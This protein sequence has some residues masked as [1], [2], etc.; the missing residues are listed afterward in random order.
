MMRRYFIAALSCILAVSTVTPAAAFEFNPSYVISDSEMLDEDSMTEEQIRAFLDA[1]GT[2]GERTFTDVDDARKGAAEI[3]YD[4][5]QRNG[6]NP[7]VILVMLQKEQSL[8]D[9]EDPT[10]DQLD[11]A[12][13][14]GICDSCNYRTESAQRFRGSW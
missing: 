9:D 13:G 14:Y 2:L 10:G 3:I 7:R 8:I 4:A 1:Y 5:A 6:I 12:M 11:W